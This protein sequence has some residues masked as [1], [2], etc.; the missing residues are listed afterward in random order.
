MF[1][2]GLQFWYFKRVWKSPKKMD[3]P[4]LLE[5]LVDLP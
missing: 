5:T 3:L 4:V 2:S 1:K